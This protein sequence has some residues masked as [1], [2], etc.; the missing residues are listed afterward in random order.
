M[1]QVEAKSLGHYDV[2]VAGGGIAG[3]CAAVAAARNG[4][5]VILIES[6]GCLGGTVTEGLMGNLCD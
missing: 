3:V 5:K 1:Y 4:A 2:A 6:A